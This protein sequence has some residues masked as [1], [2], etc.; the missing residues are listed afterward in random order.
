MIRGPP[1]KPSCTLPCWPPSQPDGPD[2]APPQAEPSVT[3]TSNVEALAATTSGA[4]LSGQTLPQVWQMCFSKHHCSGPSHCRLHLRT[5]T[6]CLACAGHAAVLYR[7]G[8]AADHAERWQCRP[9]SAL[10]AT[11]PPSLGC[12]SALS[13]AAT[14]RTMSGPG[15]AITDT[16]SLSVRRAACTVRYNTTKVQ[17]VG[18]NG[19]SAIW[20]SGTFSSSPQPPYQLIMQSVRPEPRHGYMLSVI[21]HAQSGMHGRTS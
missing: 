15:T 7:H 4:L 19:A 9:V 11:G 6:L 21:P 1:S 17:A 18:Y 12:W 14:R 2:P 8:R 5:P 3:T 20:Q 10:L 13:G 16:G